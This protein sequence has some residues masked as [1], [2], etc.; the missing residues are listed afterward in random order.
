MAKIATFKIETSFKITG[1][2]LVALGQI[3][4]GTVRIGAYAN[5]EVDNKRVTKQISAVEMADINREKGEYAVG[6][7]FVYK[8][9]AERKEFETK[10]L[11]DQIIDIVDEAWAN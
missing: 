1:R 6:L 7:L 2:G 5:F 9:E 4:E 3:I 10:K 8:D 11:K